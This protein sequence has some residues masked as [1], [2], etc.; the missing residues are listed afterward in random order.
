ML[1]LDIDSY[2]IMLILE[3]LHCDDEE[4]LCISMEE[5]EDIMVYYGVPIPEDNHLRTGS[6][7][8]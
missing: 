4:Y 2:N 3:C 7:V 5:L 6:N 1:E 8:G